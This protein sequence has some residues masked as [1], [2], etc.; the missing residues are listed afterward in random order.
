[1]MLQMLYLKTNLCG[2]TFILYCNKGHIIK[3][4][5]PLARHCDVIQP[6]YQGR[7]ETLQGLNI[8]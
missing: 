5:Y 8:I 2:S 7:N 4:Y 6:V 3:Y 1:M